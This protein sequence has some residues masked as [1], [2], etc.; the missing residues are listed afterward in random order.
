VGG[1]QRGRLL[2]RVDDRRG[3]RDEGRETDWSRCGP[4]LVDSTTLTRSRRHVD[5]MY[6]GWRMI[7]Y[8]AR[9]KHSR[10]PSSRQIGGGALR[11]LRNCLF[12]K[13]LWAVS[14]IQN[15]KQQRGA[16]AFSSVQRFNSILALSTPFCHPSI[17]PPLGRSLLIITTRAKL[18]PIIPPDS[19]SRRLIGGPPLP[20]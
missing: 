10:V 6:S 11:G 7:Y 12:G 15:R 13:L 14:R 4:S 5:S 2:R 3:T 9:V 20:R 18:P 19:S 1:R 16:A 8:P 17:L